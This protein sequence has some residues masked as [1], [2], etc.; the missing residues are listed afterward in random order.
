[1]DNNQNTF[2]FEHIHQD[3]NFVSQ[4]RAVQSKA[5][6]CKQFFNICALM[7]DAFQ[8]RLQEHSLI[9]SILL[10]LSTVTITKVHNKG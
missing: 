5:P 8:R 3:V 9:T 1:V 10:R 4:N 2:T 6:Y 7:N